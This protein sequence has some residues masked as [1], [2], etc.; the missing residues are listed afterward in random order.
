EP[1]LRAILPGAVPDANDCCYA[2][3]HRAETGERGRLS[4]PRTDFSGS[5][6]VEP[7]AAIVA[8]DETGDCFGEARDCDERRERAQRSEPRERSEPAERLPR[9]RVGEFEGRS[10]SGRKNVEWS[11]PA[12]IVPDGQCPCGADSARPA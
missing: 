4:G 6:E 12:G 1:R 3:A 10:P 9:E 2:S 11:H 5:G 7:V 8:I